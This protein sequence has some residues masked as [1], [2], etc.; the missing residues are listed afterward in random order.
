VDLVRFELTTSSMP[1]K[2]YQWVADIFTRNKRLS[3]MR[4]GRQWT[5]GPKCSAFGLRCGLQDDLAPGPITAG[6]TSGWS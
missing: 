2:K 1:F 4:F 3:A 5:P 6:S